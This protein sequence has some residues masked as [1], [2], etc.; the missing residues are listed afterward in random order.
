[1]V[2]IVFIFNFIIRVLLNKAL[3]QQK[4]DTMTNYN[5]EKVYLNAIYQSLNLGFFNLVI[6]FLIKLPNIY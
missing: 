1:M 6:P 2:F 5:A 4:I 3:D